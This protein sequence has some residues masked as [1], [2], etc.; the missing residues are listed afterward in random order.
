MNLVQEDVALVSDGRADGVVVVRLTAVYDNGIDMGGL[1]AF[2]RTNLDWLAGQVDAALDAWGYQGVEE[3]HGRDAFR[4][5]GGGTDA[6]PVV[7]V[8]N[9]RP[10]DAPSPGVCTLSMT[11]PVATKLRDIL[12]SI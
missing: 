3:T 9:E 10:A 11:Q 1:F 6:Q 8:Q 7:N 5:F 12:R 2:D 4:V